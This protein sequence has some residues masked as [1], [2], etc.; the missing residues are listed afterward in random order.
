MDRLRAIENDYSLLGGR[1]LRGSTFRYGTIWAIFRCTAYQC[2]YCRWIFKLNWGPFNSLI[3]TGERA[4]WHCK[5]IFWDGSNEWP[6]MSSEDR[7]L[8]LL[9]LTIAGYIA[10]FL[11]TAGLYVYMLVATKKPA[12]RGELLF[13][14]ELVLPVALWFCFRG[15]QVIRSVHRYNNRVPQGPS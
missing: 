6:E 15:V 8:F 11:V 1:G 3:G 12:S 4:C 2:P 7:Q 13:L 5:Q 9:P 14:I 10:G